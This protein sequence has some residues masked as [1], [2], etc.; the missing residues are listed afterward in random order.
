MNEND[1]GGPPS[2]GQPGSGS[3]PEGQPP[4][5]QELRHSQVSARVPEQV[6]LGVFCTGVIVIQS[7]HEF[8]LD[9]LQN[10]VQPHRIAARV[11]LPPSVVPLFVAALQENVQKFQHTFGALPRMPAPPPGA[12]P[13][14][15]DIYEQLKLPED[16]ISGVYANAVMIVHSPGEFCFDFITNFYPRSAVACRVY[17]SVSHVPQ[18]LDSLIHAFEQFRRK[19]SQ[20]PPPNPPA[21]N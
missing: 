19:M 9:F 12:A 1:K 4:Q 18:F 15:S 2:P 17:L 13:P 5:H 10:L 20:P 14:V 16:L 8:V 7:A 11:V 3:P 6:G 21:Q